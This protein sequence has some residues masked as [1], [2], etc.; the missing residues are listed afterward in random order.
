MQETGD[1]PEVGRWAPDG[2]EAVLALDNSGTL[3]TNT[4]VGR[5]LV[6]NAEWASPVPDAPVDRGRLALISVDHDS[7]SCL[8]VDRPLGEVLVE[9]DVS[10]YLA[11]SNCDVTLEE[12]REVVLTEETPARELWTQAK[13]ATRQMGENDQEEHVPGVQVVVDVST[14]RVL[15][16]VG[17][18]ATPK[19]E[20]RDIVEWA[21]DQG[22]EP[23][24]VS[25]DTATILQ[26]VADTVAVDAANVHP[27]QS[28]ADKART[29][30]QLR[31]RIGAPVVMVGDYVNDRLA[32]D[33]ADVAVFI[34]DEENEM[35]REV[36]AP[37]ADYRIPDLRALPSAL[38]PSFDRSW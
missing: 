16:F 5:A 28:P 3:S 7:L 25:G 17:Y 22:Y 12:A 34:D 27:Y 37:R 19:P 31:D 38:S 20:A 15:R 33:T 18:V 14:A 26:Q 4:A 10:L 11:L 24:V 8:R 32:F 35:V 2:V 13:R 29:V 9:E 21:R 1:D 36:L 30:R 6:P 23:H